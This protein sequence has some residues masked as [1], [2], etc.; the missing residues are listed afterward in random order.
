MISKPTIG[1]PIDGWAVAYNWG[2]GSRE[3]NIGPIIGR[4]RSIGKTYMGS[5][6]ERSLIFKYE[7]SVILKFDCSIFWTS[8]SILCHKHCK[9]NLNSWLFLIVTQQFAKNFPN[10]LYD[11]QENP[12][13]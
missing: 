5:T 8:P 12:R 4:F 13:N 10:V 7:T 3:T 9:K 1:I 2:T 11:L 6:F